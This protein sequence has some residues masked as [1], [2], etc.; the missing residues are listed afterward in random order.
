M[1]PS[2]LKTIFVDGDLDDPSVLLDVHHPYP[3]KDLLL[4]N[5]FDDVEDDAHD[6]VRQK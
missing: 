3:D 1:I 6:Q 2:T 5:H 4:T